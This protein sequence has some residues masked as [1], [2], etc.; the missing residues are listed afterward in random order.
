MGKRAKRLKLWFVNHVPVPLLLIGVAV[1]V[2]LCLNDDVS[3]S[4]NYQYMQEIAELKREI[5]L[6]RD[7]ARYYKEKSDQLTSSPEV[8]EHIAREQYGMQKPDEEVFLLQ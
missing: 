4:R 6:N 3:I 7:S 1:I 8:L 5:K 2:L